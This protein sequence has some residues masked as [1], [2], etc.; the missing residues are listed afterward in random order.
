[1][2]GLPISNYNVRQLKK[3]AIIFALFLIVIFLSASVITALIVDDIEIDSTHYKI[4]DGFPIFTD[5]EEYLELIKSY[6]YDFG[7]TI[8]TYIVKK[9]ESYW[10]IT[11]KMNISMD[12]LLAANPF[13]TSLLAQE[14]I[15]IVIPSEDGVLMALDSINDV[16][17]MSDLL[18]YNEDP[19]GDYTHS[20]FRLFCLDDIRFAFF[21]NS[22]PEIVN[23]SLENLYAAR[24]IFQSPICGPYTSMYGQR[25]DPFLHG[26]AFHNG[27]DI[28]GKTG[29][30]IYPAR[31]GII[32]FTG[33]KQNLGL[34]IIIQ[35]LDGYESYYGHCSA[36][37]VK[38]GDM[39]NKKQIIGK[40]G[41]TGRSTGSHL[42]FMIKRHG[43]LINPLLYIW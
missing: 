43:K 13:I 38:A 3:I 32:S 6:P 42:H 37:D 33:W 20:I 22:I 9:G 25:V 10:E 35:H 24:K 8:N 26:M 21:K 5:A 30:P 36:I 2:N 29:D 11:N 39:V 15:E 14:D 31:E 27:I 23:D 28:N 4:K 12:T 19:T 40:I 18:Q 41:S 7:T 16:W 1:M 17:R 34:T